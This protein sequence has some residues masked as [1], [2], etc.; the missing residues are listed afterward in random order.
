MMLKTAIFAAWAVMLILV[1]KFVLANDW[2][3]YAFTFV[4]AVI[5]EFLMSKAGRTKQHQQ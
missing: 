2:A 4:S 3:E 1:N 5:M